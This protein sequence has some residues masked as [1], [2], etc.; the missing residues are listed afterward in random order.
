MNIAAWLNRLG[1]GQY[2]Q[3]FN[4]NDIGAE[5]L[6]ELTAE[7]LMGLGVSSI[8]HP[9]KLRASIA[10]LCEQ[11]AVATE[12]TAPITPPATAEYG[13]RNRAGRRLAALIQ[14]GGKF[15]AR[16]ISFTPPHRPA[17]PF[18]GLRCA[19]SG[20]DLA[21]PLAYIARQARVTRLS[22]EPTFSLGAD[23]I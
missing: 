8:G 19:K 7:D 20:S 22:L 6:L 10:A 21:D 11:L 2:E 15:V 13:D 18:D 17:R 4:E 5:V 9:R 23:L 3:I 14:N 12:K 16:N 1:L